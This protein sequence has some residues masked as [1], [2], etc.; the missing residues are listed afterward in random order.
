[1]ITKAIVY[2]VNTVLALL[3]VIFARATDIFLITLGFTVVFNAVTLK[4]E[5]DLI[6]AYMIYIVSIGAWFIIILFL[7][8][9]S[10][11]THNL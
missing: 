4:K 6:T 8:A 7:T 5:Q 9:S 1:M 11:F 3:T 10:F 2:F